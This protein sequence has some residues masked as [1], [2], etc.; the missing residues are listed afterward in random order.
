[1]KANRD[2]TDW[3]GA[4]RDGVYTAS[5]AAR[6]AGGSTSRVT[7][8][9]RTRRDGSRYEPA[10]ITS[11]PPVNGQLIMPFLA[12]VEVRFVAHFRNHGLSLQTIRRV[13]AKLRADYSTDHPFATNTR[14]R[15][16]GKRV[17]MELAADDEERRLLDI[18]TDEWV[19]PTV[20]EPSLF[21]SVVYIDDLAV[22]MRPMAEF[23][24]IIVDPKFAMGR[25]VAEP[26]MVPTE[27][28]AAAFLAEGNVDEV[29]D[30]YGTDPAAVTQ[31]V[32]FEQRLAA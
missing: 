24:R 17:M 18:M 27:T 12:L 15:T 31:A 11:L 21:R 14:F 25:P 2:K 4:V 19:F 8:W 1:M 5:F 16:D 23:D 13:A 30:W 6:I 22:S 26:G 28:L 10:I 20:I 7:S 3:R 29:A 32:G 9:F